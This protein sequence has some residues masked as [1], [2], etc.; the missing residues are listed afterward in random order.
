MSELLTATVHLP[1]SCGE[2]VQGSYNGTPFHVTCPIDM[3]SSITVRLFSGGGSVTGPEH[4]AKA[5]EATH[6]TLRHLGRADLDAQLSIDSPLPPG[7]GMASSTA[8]VA[9]SIIATGLALGR[10][11]TPTE[12]ASIALSVEPSDGTFFPGIVVFDHREGKMHLDLGLPP[13]IEIVVLDFGGEVDTIAFNQQDR[14]A[15]LCRLEP[16]AQRALELV[17]QGLALSRPDLI[18]EGA[19]LSALANQEI[20]YKPQLEPVLALAR[21]VNALGVNVAHSGTVI[22]VLLDP[23]QHDV[24]RV[25]AFLRR[26]LPDME[27][28]YFASLVGGGARSGV[29][30]SRQS[31]DSVPVRTKR[32]C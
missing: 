12:V 14:S 6:L 20:L 19:T 1:G 30:P 11:L 31:P 22:G 15:I 28:M 5:V 9:G 26:N 25:G 2:L 32:R 13:P 17:R 10:R 29:V 4:A 21:Q 3:Y 7:K 18:G 16:Q 24:K 8:D 27:D 23:Q